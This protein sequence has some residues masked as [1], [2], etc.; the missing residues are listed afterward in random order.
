MTQALTYNIG[1]A[2]TNLSH[3]VA[4]A[5]NGEDVVI[6]RGGKPVVKLTPL[7]TR[8]P[9]FGFLKLDIPDPALF[10]PL[11]EESLSLWESSPVIPGK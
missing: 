10:T 3:L 9:R 4:L 8:V 7:T 5:E 6:A 1:E 11:D 2:K